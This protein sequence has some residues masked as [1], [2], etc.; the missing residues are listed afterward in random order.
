MSYSIHSIIHLPQDGKKY[1]VVDNFSS[2][3]F[4]NYLQHIKKIVRI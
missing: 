1:G 3:S 2:F 4:E